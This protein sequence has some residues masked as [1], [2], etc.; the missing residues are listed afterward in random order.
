M[1]F[2]YFSLTDLDWPYENIAFNAAGYVMD[3]AGRN[4]SRK[5]IESLKDQLQQ[6]KDKLRGRQETSPRN[7]PFFILFFQSPSL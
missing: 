1:I 3:R 6:Y 5:T 7:S 4:H 2:F